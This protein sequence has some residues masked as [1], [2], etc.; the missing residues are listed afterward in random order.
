VIENLLLLSVS[1]IGFCRLAKLSPDENQLSVAVF[2]FALTLGSF[3]G[4]IA[5][6]AAESGWPQ[7]AMIGDV[8]PTAGVLIALLS[9]SWRW[10]HGA[11][12][13]TKTHE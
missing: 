11:P 13:W 10:W 3:L 6:I 7:F 1:I 4:L 12:E 2:Y 9:G 8:L 5:K